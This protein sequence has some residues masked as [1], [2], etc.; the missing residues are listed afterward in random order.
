[1]D[2]P[3]IILR[4]INVATVKGATGMWQYHSQ[5]DHHSQVSSW[6][7]MFDLLQQSAT[8]QRHIAEE[9]VTFGVNH[10]LYNFVTGRPKKLDLVICRPADEGRG[11][12]FAEFGERC[13][14]L[15]SPAERAR[16][17]ALPAIRVSEV[18]NVLAA[19]EAKAV[20]TK[21][22]SA[23]PRLYDELNSSHQTIHSAATSALAIALV[24]IN[25]SETFISPPKNKFLNVADRVNVS[26]HKQPQAAQKAIDTIRELPRRA[27]AR[28][29]GYDGVGVLMVDAP[30]DFTPWTLVTQPPAPRPAGDVH[31]ATMLQRMG[32]E[33]DA[34]F[35]GI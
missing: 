33:Y 29:D 18:G 7:V 6:A 3:D 24:M 13:G 19:L 23:A 28:G 32:H 20:M 25:A 11:I 4:T 10:A 21:H 27:G 1:M 8:L 12:T 9:K 16:L 35:S 14:V 34:R 31:Y 15:L 30:N 26:R 5:S 22:S 2:A 17:Q